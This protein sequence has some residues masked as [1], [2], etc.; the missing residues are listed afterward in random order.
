M[1]GEWSHGWAGASRCLCEGECL[2]SLGMH[3]LH[4]ESLKRVMP[5][6]CNTAKGLAKEQEFK[7]APQGIYRKL[8]EVLT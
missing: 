1:L 8:R 3:R 2:S 4:L 5:P 7:E 6:P